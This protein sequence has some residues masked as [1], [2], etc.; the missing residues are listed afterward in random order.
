MCI[1]DRAR[2]IRIPVH[3]VE[4]IN[5]MRQATNQL[6]YQNGHQPT[7]EE[8]AKAMD[9]SCLLYTSCRAAAPLHLCY[10]Q[11]QRRLRHHF[12]HSQLF[13]KRCNEPEGGLSLIHN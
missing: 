1:R 10:Q 6:V 5:R 13:Q 8:L 9:M 11:I 4:T 12:C 3:M 7:P 2:T